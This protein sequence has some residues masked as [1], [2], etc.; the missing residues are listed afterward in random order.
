MAR[1]L[2]AMSGGV[3]SSVAAFLLKKRGFDVIGATMKLSP[4]CKTLPEDEKYVACCSDGAI[5]QAKEIAQKIDIKHYVLNFRQ[6]F[7]E[8]VI[9]N[10]YKEYKRGRTPNPCVRC[11]K[12]IKFDA[13]LK[14]ARQ[15]GA[16]YICTGHYA[17]IQYNRVHKKFL[18]KR[19][20]DKTK[21]QS[22]ALYILNRKNLRH[23]L[24]PLGGLT[25]QEVRKIAREAKFSNYARQESQELCFVAQKDYR[26]FIAK[27]LK[28]KVGEIVD[29]KG[30]ILGKHKGIYFYTI[31][32]RRGLGLS[33][34]R[35]Y[36]VVAIDWR[37]NRIVV[38][39][40]EELYARSLVADNLNFLSLSNL[41]KPLKAKAKIRYKH[42]SQEAAIY[43]IDK[44][45]VRVEFKKPQRAI[46][47]G[48]AV[49]FYQGEVVIGGGVIKRVEDK[50]S[51]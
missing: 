43:K 39:F 31:G 8:T 34:A 28:P 33:A 32:Q 5:E 45:T 38:G 15:L 50:K 30:N 44:D 16:D 46:T 35:P 21:D 10:F 4:P 2:V 6:V 1:V 37:K 14:K 27:F 42:L 7:K 24:F 26:K 36:Y 9:D 11:N 12:F 47:P 29:S 48:Q 23:I 51:D 19:A 3:D 25:K 40:E 20:K 22:Y 49:V 41:T 17:K 18:L 13:L